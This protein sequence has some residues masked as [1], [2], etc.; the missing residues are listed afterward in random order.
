MEGKYS[1]SEGGGE[2]HE[3]A[4]SG[5]SKMVGP[6]LLQLILKIPTESKNSTNEGDWEDRE[7]VVSGPPKMVG[8]R[9][10]QR[11]QRREYQDVGHLVEM[12]GKI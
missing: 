6:E 1:T 2:D 7:V 8:I 3:V 11:I 5:P 10:L 12:H 9:L 4:M